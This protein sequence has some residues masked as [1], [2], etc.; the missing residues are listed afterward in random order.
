M[1]QFLISAYDFTDSEALSRRMAARAAHL[2]N[3]QVLKE[4]G[5]FIKAGAYLNEKGDMIGSAMMMQ[6]EDRA[7]LDLYLENEPYVGQKVWEN[8]EVKEIRIANI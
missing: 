4:Q 6:F 8:I 5:H 7:A 1:K 2:E 3:I